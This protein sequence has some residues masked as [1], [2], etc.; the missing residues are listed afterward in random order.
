MPLLWG[1]TAIEEQPSP[2]PML[3]SS[4]YLLIDSSAEPLSR[5]VPYQKAIRIGGG[6]F[7]VLL[8]LLAVRDLEGG[9]TAETRS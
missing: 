7:L 9:M 4:I 2:W 1:A 6:V 8:G 3:T 5:L